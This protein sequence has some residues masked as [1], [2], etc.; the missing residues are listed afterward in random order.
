VTQGDQML[1]EKSPNN[2]PKWPKMMTNLHSYIAV[3]ICLENKY[4]I[5]Y[6]LISKTRLK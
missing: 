2:L 3:C 1:S 4:V 6:L 5:Y